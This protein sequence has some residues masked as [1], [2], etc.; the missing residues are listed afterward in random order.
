MSF[1]NSQSL[2]HKRNMLSSLF[3]MMS[4]EIIDPN[5]GQLAFYFT[6]NMKSVITVY[7]DKE[8]QRPLLEC[9]RTVFI[10]MEW[11]VFDLENANQHIGHFKADLMRNLKT[12]GRENWEITDPGGS[13]LLIFEADS[14]DSIGKRMM[15]NFTNL[16]NPN[17]QYNIWDANKKPVAR[18]WSKHGLWNFCY[19]MAFEEKVTDVERK[20]SIALLAAMMLM[21]KK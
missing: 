6:M 8:K 2:H 4:R 7:A 20:M 17:F 18:I 9:K 12:L 16:Y 21:L 10:G 14:T 13:P 11:D 5:T 19:D 15:D 3:H 1:P